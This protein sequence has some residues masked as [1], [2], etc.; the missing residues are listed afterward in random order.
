MSDIHQVAGGKWPDILS[1]LGVPDEYLQN[2]HGPCPICG[3]KDRYRFDDNEGKGMYYCNQCG[4]GDGI[5]L[6]MKFNNWD[7]VQ[8]KKEVESIVGK[9]RERIIQHPSDP[10]K[11][12]RAIQANSGPAGYE[13]ERYLRNRGLSKVPPGLREGKD[14]YFEDGRKVGE[15][16]VMLGKVVN[17]SGRPVTWHV[18]YLDQGQKANVK[19]PKKIMKGIESFAGGAIRLF[20]IEPHIGIAEGIET[21]IAAAE[22][23]GIP[24]WSVINAHGM[25]TFIPP[26]G[27]GKITVFGDTDDSYT[28]QK[29]AYHAA[30]WLKIKGYK[31]SVKLPD[32]GDWLDVLN[33]QRKARTA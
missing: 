1:R 18:T 21:A 5:D 7:F 24:V 10:L 17:I 11:R 12:L 19:S 29:A 3:G 33:G 15:F 20:P 8:C 23:F 30:Q 32:N 14:W 27:V 28:G 9:C 2:R 4:A 16:P 22:L 25:E 13:V 6:L 26:E 31:V